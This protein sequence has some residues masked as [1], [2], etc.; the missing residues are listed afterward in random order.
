MK[1]TFVNNSGQKITRKVGFSWTTL[2]FLAI[3]PLFRKDWKWFGI[4]VASLVIL[5]LAGQ[6]ILQNGIIST[7]INPA[8]ALFFA[9]TYNKFHI[10]DL[11]NKGFNP[12]DK[13]AEEIL[14]QKN[15]IN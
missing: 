10:K 1:V 12:I 6:F 7:L 11:L 14:K 5:N 13:E 2:F 4:I 9:F 15:Y 3:P 8:I